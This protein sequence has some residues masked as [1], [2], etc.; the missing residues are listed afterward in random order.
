MKTFNTLVIFLFLGFSAN[1]QF[2]DNHKLVIGGSV[3]GFTQADILAISPRVGKVLSNGNLAGITGT[4]L[5][6]GG[7][8]NSV[9]VFGW[10]RIIK[11][12]EVR[13]FPIFYRSDIQ[14]G[15]SDAAFGGGAI[16]SY[17]PGFTIPLTKKTYLD[18][19]LATLQLNYDEELDATISIN[20]IGLGLLFG[21]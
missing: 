14:A 3:Q 2:Q 5:T 13:S 17:A 11:E 15:Y 6:T 18:I 7:E 19:T 21:L 20:N 1:A 4:Y 12:L 8:N 10:Y 9:G 16:I